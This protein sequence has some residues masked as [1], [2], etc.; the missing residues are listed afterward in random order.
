MRLLVC[1][2]RNWKNYNII[3]NILKN[4][5]PSV[6]IQG[7]ARGVDSLAK[8]AAEELGVKVLSFPAEWNRYG[9]A[10]GPIRNEKMLKEGKP[11]MVI[12]FHN[13]IT[14]SKGTKNC[15]IQAKKMGIPTILVEEVIM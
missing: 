15:L 4:I 1:G 3:H 11:D 9:R 6:I 5:H 13:D 2:D 8:R 14:K 10:A 12:A 7:E